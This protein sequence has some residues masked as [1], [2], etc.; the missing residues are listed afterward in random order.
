MKL[1][2][3]FILTGHQG[4]GKTTKLTKV[5]SLLKLK[6]VDIFGFIATGEWENNLRSRFHLKDI[7]SERNYL[8]CNREE[9]PGTLNGIFVFNMQTIKT[10]EQII[11]EGMK[12]AKALAVIDEIGRFELKEKVWYPVFKK[13]AEKN[14]PTLITVRKSLL[15]PIIEK[16]GIE[17]PVIFNLE[18]KSTFI[19]N[20]IFEQVSRTNI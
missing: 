4:E 17:H 3:V 8:L 20:K 2:N 1:H 10:G 9:K 15:K 14:F 19:A 7:N 13:L 16:F 12:H 5:I 6:G 18:D 11:T